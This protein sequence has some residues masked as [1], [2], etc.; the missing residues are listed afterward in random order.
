MLSTKK[1]LPLL[2][3]LVLLAAACNLLESP[4]VEP[5]GTEPPLTEEPTLDDLESPPTGSE[6][7]PPGITAPDL[8]GTAA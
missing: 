8:T 4:P 7:L 2:L 6:A 5:E 3:I 1:Y